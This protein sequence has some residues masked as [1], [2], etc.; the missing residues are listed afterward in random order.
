MQVTAIVPT[1]NRKQMVCEIVADLR[2]QNHPL[3]IVVVDNGSDDGTPEAC[4]QLGAH[5][6]LMG[7]NAGF[8]AAVNRGIG[9]ASG[10]WVAILNND[11]RVSAEWLATLLGAATKAG[12][13]FAGSRL[14]RAADP[15]QMDGCF[16]LL[17]RGGCAWRAGQ[18]RKDGPLW[19]RARRIAFVPF[20]AAIFR[21]DLFREVGLLDESFE[22]YLEDVEFGLRCALAGRAGLYVPEAVAYH[23][24]SATWGAWSPEMVRLL[25]RNQILLLARHGALRRNWWPALL[26]QAA[27]GVVAWR[28][29]AGLAW[30]RGKREGF[31]LAHVMKTLPDDP[32]KLD[33]IL[34][35]SE[36][37]LRKLQEQ[38]GFDW[39]WKLYF[40]LT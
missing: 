7:R 29:S 15:T 28:H 3:E 32:A 37:E 1:W 10:E 5:V 4:R 22:S 26:A 35:E 23:T 40:Y 20:T 9:E 30:C 13:A 33:A 12:A 14:L 18:G 31:R 24:G 25:A 2:R 34:R 11:V 27:W 39:F 6:I 36:V 17:C 19:R 21:R 8:A 38:T 16:D